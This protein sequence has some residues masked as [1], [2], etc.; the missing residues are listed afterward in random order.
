MSLRRATPLFL[1]LW[2]LACQPS[3][4]TPDGGQVA[5]PPVNMAVFNTDPA[6]PTIP[7]PVP[8]PNDLAI[9]ALGPP[10][11]ASAK[12]ELAS[13]L[14][15]TYQGAA[16]DQ[17]GA[18]ITFTTVTIDP[19]TGVSTVGPLSLTDPID[20]ATVNTSTVAMVRT[21]ADEVLEVDPDA[22]T[23]D[24]DPNTP[25]VG[26]L[27]LVPKSSA[28]DRRWPQGARMVVAIR[29]GPDGIKTMSGA[30]IQASE[31]I[32][33][34]TLPAV[35]SAPLG[36]LDPSLADSLLVA[37]I[38][39]QE[40]ALGP[41]KL[42]ALRQTYAKPK[43]W[44]PCPYPAGCPGVGITY[45][46][47][48]WIP[49]D[50]TTI[51][52]TWISAFAAVDR[53]FPHAEVASIQTFTVGTLP[54]TW[55]EIDS[56]AGRVPLPSSFIDLKTLAHDDGTPTA[57]GKSFGALA[58]GLATLDGFSTT[59]MLLAPTSA[60]VTA[61]LINNTTTFVFDLTNPTS[62]VLL[63]D[64][65][66][67]GPAAKYFTE[68]PP[69]TVDTGT[70]LAC[71]GPPYGSTCVST[72]IGLQPAV[73]VPL[74]G[75]IY[76]LPPLK[77]STTYAVVITKSAGGGLVRN[78]IDRLLFDFTNPLHDGAHSLLPNL[79]DTQAAG[80][81]QMRQ[82]FQGVIFPTLN[83]LKG[84]SA[85]DVAM[86]YTF[87]TQS[88]TGKGSVPGALQFAALPDSLPSFPD[89]LT[90]TTTL[91]PAQAEQKYGLPSTLG[92]AASG[93]VAAV[94]EA[95]LVTWDLLDP[96]S[97]AFHT[98]AADGK[99]SSIPALVVIPA[100]LP[101]SA[102]LVVFRH[103]INQARAD[104]LLIA[105]AL[106]Q[107]GMVAVAIDA[108]KHGDRAWCK[109]GSDTDC[110]TGTCVAD[111]TLTNQGDALDSAPGSCKL[112]DGS[113][114]QLAYKPLSSACDQTSG[115]WNGTGGK[116]KASGNFFFSANLF[117]TRDSFRQ[118]IIDQSAL[119]RAV[120]SSNGQ[121]ALRAAL[122]SP[123]AFS[124]DSAEV[125]YVGQSLGAIQGTVNIA[126]NPR[127]SKAVLNA[128]GGALPDIFDRSPAFSTQIAQLLASLGIEKGTS[129]Y[130]QFLQV[131]KWVLDPAD[132]INFA[133]NLVTSPLPNLLANPDGSVAQSAKTVLGQAA[134]CDNV[135]PNSTNELLYGLIGLK[136][137]NPLGDPDGTG[138]GPLQWYMV[139]TTTACPD[140]GSTG[141]GGA[142]HGFLLDFANQSLT[143]KA[144]TDAATFLLAGSVANPTPVTP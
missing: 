61:S 131:A 89:A 64:L 79:T 71:S 67:A 55:V 19:A 33:V 49:A 83:A 51:H 14:I 30:Q 26:T 126:A 120:T 135:V 92:L 7:S 101:A 80:F 81:Q 15:S 66:A 9:Q 115:C 95:N 140:D 139:D 91:T 78:T 74:G 123:G 50:A 117:R 124:I 48:T 106:A 138:T 28:S 119:V 97:G 70:G 18:Q 25:T 47:G 96:A 136:P 2:T 53:V 58:A 37:S 110:A 54:G 113:A 102:P 82:L 121:T 127:F 1:G 20:M 142:A 60:P 116:A 42:E 12:Q 141:A 5:T 31:P 114:G 65:A 144:Q 104:L 109:V 100:S 105:R 86:A 75:A 69:I 87:K 85:S 8:S 130:L 128:G 3:L 44:M 118:D 134:R 112:A 62:P 17:S 72:V 111:A 35:E 40:G 107:G 10:G 77:E 143:T 108:D 57:T 29:G 4:N 59:A 13:L 39:A 125:Y 94:I 22:S 63:N 98:S 129:A 99:A 73:T 90:V 41:A 11:T 52:P 93:A 16:P 103:G 46:Q 36:L 6:A 76:T 122:S 68:P 43:M 132:P 88:I 34:I 56:A 84:V 27:T 133:Q 32:Q 24:V 38:V 45:P 23:F 137:V 21:D